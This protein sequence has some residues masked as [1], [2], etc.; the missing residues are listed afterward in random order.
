MSIHLDTAILLLNVGKKTVMP[1]NEEFAVEVY[2][3]QR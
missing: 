1:G 3:L 2:I